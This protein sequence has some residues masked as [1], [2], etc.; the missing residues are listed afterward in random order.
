MRTGA[1][2]AAPAVPG[3]ADGHAPIRDY[4]IIGDGR[5]VALVARDGAIDWLSLP[6]LDSP[7]IFGALLDARR[8]GA[9]ELAP[10]IPFTVA[11]RY[12]PDTNV[13]ETAFVTDEG[14]VKVTDALTLTGDGLA[15]AREL[16]R[17]VEPQSG[18][19]PMKWSVE[20]RF[21]YAAARTR[22]SARLGVPVA[23]RR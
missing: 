9:F 2:V 15:P 12:V 1:A 17:R 8:G 11:R 14:I 6:N 5:T 22:I 16:A 21:G 10:E 19:V 23:S 4:A 20:P 13:L 18:L 3:R 7:S